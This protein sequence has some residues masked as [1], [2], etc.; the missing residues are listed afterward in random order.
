MDQ[1]RL[2]DSFGF[3]ALVTVR[4]IDQV[5]YVRIDGCARGGGALVPALVNVSPLFSPGRWQDCA[6]PGSW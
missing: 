6:L 1:V 2:I 5:E 3:P 4:R